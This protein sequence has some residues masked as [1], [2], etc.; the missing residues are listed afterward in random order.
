VFVIRGLT[1]SPARFQGLAASDK[2][3]P[4]CV[5]STARRRPRAVKH[6]D[7]NLSCDTAAELAQQRA[8]AANVKRIDFTDSIKLWI[9]PT[10]RQIPPTAV[11]RI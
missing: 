4:G 11:E 7:S 8:A 6:I 5:I 9:G 2:C 10:I 1:N 3:V